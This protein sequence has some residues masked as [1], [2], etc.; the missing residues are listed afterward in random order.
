M[1]THL[2]N[3]AHPL[4]SRHPNY[5]WSQLANDGLWA[6]L[7]GDGHHLPPSTLKAMV[8]AKGEKAVLVSDANHFEGYPPGRYL[9]RNRHGVILE[10][11]GRLVMADNPLIFSGAAT[12]LNRC[13]ENV[14]KYGIRTLGEAIQMASER[15]AAM[16]G[17]TAGG[18]GSCSQEPPPTGRFQRA[19]VQN[20]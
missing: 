8:R 13:V 14:S 19:G 1:S 5:I 10:A 17:L 12:P 3:G 18:T 9:K 15:L 20:S 7:I 11:G 6:G 4:F 16:L 2:G